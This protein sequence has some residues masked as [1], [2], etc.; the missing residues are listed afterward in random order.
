M[1][2]HYSTWI[3][4]TIKAFRLANEMTLSDLGA[5]T[6]L[7][8]SYLSDLERGRT[9]PPLD[10]L[11]KIL[12]TFGTTLTLGVE[13]DYTPTGYMWVK[14]KTLDRLAAIVKEITPQEG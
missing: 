11:D 3:P 5:K 9:I 7:S 4:K 13:E 14:R 12:T 1:A 10:T 6:G 8:I 2:E